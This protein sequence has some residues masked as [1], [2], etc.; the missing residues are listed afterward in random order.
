M[1]MARIL[2]AVHRRVRAALA[3]TGPDLVRTVAN[4]SGQVNPKGD[5]SQ[6]FDLVADDLIRREL[7][8]LCSSGVVL[9]EERGDEVVFGRQPPRYRFVVDPVDGSDNHMRGLPLAAV[10]VAV[11]AGKGPLG[12]EQ[13]V[14]ALVGGLDREEPLLA[15]RRKGAWQGASRLRTSQVRRIDE[16]LVS[17]EL[18]HWAPD[19]RLAELLRRSRGVRTYGCASR[20]GICASSSWPWVPSRATPSKRYL[21]RGCSHT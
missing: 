5:V 8:R 4:T 18:N 16:A 10:S 1:D 2:E 3:G 7:E 13:V 14:H 21:W 20:G 9:S 11:L 6:P 15:T 12:L 19:G 17:C